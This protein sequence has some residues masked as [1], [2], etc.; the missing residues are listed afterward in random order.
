[1]VAVSFISAPPATATTGQANL[2][3]SAEDLYGGVTVPAGTWVP[4]AVTVTNRGR[5]GFAGDLVVAGPPGGPAPGG[6]CIANGPTTSTCLG[7]AY[8]ATSLAV[9]PGKALQEEV[10]ILLAAGTEKTFY[11]LVWAT[12]SG[13]AQAYLLGHSGRLLA[14]ATTSV[15]VSSGFTPPAVLV[16]T[17]APSAT[18][19]LGKLSTPSGAPVQLLYLSPSQLPATSPP[20]GAFRAIAIDDANTAYLSPAQAQ[21]LASYVA[22]GGTIVVAGGAAWAAGTAGLPASLLGGLA[23]QPS[24][25]LSSSSLPKLGLALGAPPLRAAVDYV[26]LETLPGGDVALAAGGRPLVV[27]ARRGSG[28]VVLCAFDPAAPPISTWAGERELLRLVFAPAWQ[29]GYFASALPYGEAG[30]IFPGEPENLAATAAQRPGERGGG[31]SLLSPELAARVF[32][33]WLRSA[34]VLLLPPPAWEL[35]LLLAGYV[36]VA[37]PVVFFVLGRLRRP[38]LVW[39]AVPALAGAVVA[40]GALAWRTTPRPVASEVRVVTVVPGNPMAEVASVGTVELPRGG[41]A[42]I[43]L[44]GGGSLTGGLGPGEAEVELGGFGTVQGEGL[45]AAR[46]EISS[47][48]GSVPGWVAS[49][50]ARVT[51]ALEAETRASASAVAGV[52]TNRLGTALEDARV[53]LAYGEATASLGSLLPGGSAHFQL[54]VEPNATP[55]PQAFGSPAIEAVLRVA[56]PRAGTGPAASYAAR[57]RGEQL[58]GLLQQLAESYS[59]ALGGAPVFAALASGNVV[60]PDASAHLRSGGAPEVVLAALPLSWEPSGG[61]QALLVGS[62]GVSGEV[63]YGLETD[64]LA[65]SKGGFFEYE[66]FVPQRPEQAAKLPLEVGLGSSLGAWRGLVFSAS[67][68]DW[69]T[70]RWH[71]LAIIARKGQLYAPL[72]AAAGPAAGRYVSLYLHDGTL[73]LRVTARS[74]GTEVYGEYPTLLAMSSPRDL[75]RR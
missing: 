13:R 59:A 40:A 46:L 32:G 10:P 8:G 11:P 19:S 17:D 4:L 45:G 58:P 28:H 51:G 20:L 75:G 3:V 25:E 14:K 9:V 69:A 53:V 16:V 72:P 33:P 21:A 18:T 41:T 52:V 12:G 54:E 48:P 68:F 63:P 35:G 42:R 73:E 60:A 55:D 27:F 24:G 47:R 29:P 37:G 31:T 5:S 66:F 50:A 22:F 70:G 71:E 23:G 44:L 26:R 74:G 61:L 1:M 6:G 64:A 49:E 57:S 7:G 39:V 36:I 38:G 30:G 15:E 62:R 2:A 65:I 56:S 43:S 67:A 34:P